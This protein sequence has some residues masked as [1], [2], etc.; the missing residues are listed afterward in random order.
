MSGLLRDEWCTPEWLA[1]ALGEFDLDPCSN[2]RS[3]IRAR[4]TLDGHGE[5]GDGLAYVPHHGLRVFSN[6]PYSR[7]QVIKWVR[8]YGMTNFTFLLRW[9]PSTVWYDELMSVTRLTWHP[10][11]RLQFEPPPCV[12]ASSNPFPHALYFRNPPEKEVYDRLANLGRFFA[13]S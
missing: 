4:A 10:N 12:K 5:L 8:R 2:S 7:G 1:D 9:D 3:H 11:R 6:P 13:P